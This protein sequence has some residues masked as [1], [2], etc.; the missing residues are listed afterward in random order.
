ME[1]NR[2]LLVVKDFDSVANLAEFA[3]IIAKQTGASITGMHII[4]VPYQVP[5]D[6]VFVEEEEIAND[7][8]EKIGL[9]AR[10]NKI[11]FA[12][13]IRNARTAADGILD[14]AEEGKYDLIVMGISRRSALEK[15][16]REDVIK[17]VIKEAPCEVCIV[18][19]GK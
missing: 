18:R 7:T 17:K 16:F 1:I 6:A 5:R 8:L 10:K 9:I 2:I 15:I 3:F 11:R 19:R 4:E 12:K 13:K 14:E